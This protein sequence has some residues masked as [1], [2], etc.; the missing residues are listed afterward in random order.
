MDV[1][2]AVRVVR[3]RAAEWKVDP[4]H[5]AVL[6]FSA[7]GHLA[8]CYG[9]HWQRYPFA[10]EDPL[11]KI[12]NQPNAQVLCYPVI[13]SA[14]PFAH[15][16]S[17]DNLLGPNPSADLLREM[18]LE[19]QMS[20]H[21]PPA[22]IWHTWSDEYVPVENSMLFAQGMRRCGRPFEL[23][24]YPEGHHGIGLSPDDPHAA[25]W[26]ELCCQWLAGQG[27]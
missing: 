13:T 5:V 10:K 25:T 12:S 27:W 14:D 4:A 15:R 23:H 19:L 24:I 26:M 17:F 22:F 11:H 2:R 3:Q 20:E 9:V 1:S 21:T 16:G 18:S 6:G 8:A 7:G